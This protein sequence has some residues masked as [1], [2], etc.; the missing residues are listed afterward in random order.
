MVKWAT[1]SLNDYRKC[2]VIAIL[3]VLISF[4]PEQNCFH[5]SGFLDMHRSEC[6]EILSQVRS[7]YYDMK[8]KG[9]SAQGNIIFQLVPISSDLVSELVSILSDIER[10]QWERQRLQRSFDTT[11]TS[12]AIQAKY[13]QLKAARR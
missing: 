13:H 11:R 1:Q 8:V 10:E 9:G 7:P 6:L 3:Q 12:A 2:Y 4:V 5:I